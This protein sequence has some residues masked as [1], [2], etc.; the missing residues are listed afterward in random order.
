MY[1][2]QILDHLYR[3]QI[4][5]CHDDADVHFDTNS[6][7]VIVEF[8]NLREYDENKVPGDVKFE[9][10]KALR[11]ARLNG[12]YELNLSILDLHVEDK[13]LKQKGYQITPEDRHKKRSNASSY[14]IYPKAGDYVQGIITSVRFF[15]IN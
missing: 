12:K 4:I 14:C 1:K 8:K 13:Y 11:F 5:S 2:D 15:K 6:T 10:Y 9:I 7:R 3:N